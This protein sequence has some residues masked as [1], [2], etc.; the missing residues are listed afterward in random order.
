MA[1]AARDRGVPFHTD[2]IQALGKIPVDVDDLGVDLLSGA[3]HK[4]YGP[5]GGGFLYVRSGTALRPVLH[6][7]HQQDGLRPGTVDVPAAAGVAAALRLATAELEATAERLERMVQHMEETLLALP[8]VTRNG[9]PTGRLPGTLNLT[10]SG[11][12]A[13]ALLIALDREG[14]SIGTGSACATGAALPSH[15]LT[16]MGRT[17]LEVTSSIRLSPGRGT[18]PADLERLREVFPEIVGRLRAIATGS[19]S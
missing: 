19:V 8:G 15:V 5:K 2:A 11:V 16:A 14:F 13:E 7:G 17:P 6:G 9:P 12:A 10:V 18:A 3:A 4:F 1:A